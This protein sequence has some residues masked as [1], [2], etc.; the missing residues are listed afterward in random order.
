MIAVENNTKQNYFN[1]EFLI[2]TGDYIA[3]VEQ[4]AAN[5]TFCRIYTNFPKTKATDERNDVTDNNDPMSCNVTIRARIAGRVTPSANTNCLEVIEIP[6]T[7]KSNYASLKHIF[8][9]FA[10]INSPFLWIFS[11]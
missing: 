4:K 8:F 11:F 5:Q 6:L 7:R 2:G 1:I 10:C 9:L 3:T